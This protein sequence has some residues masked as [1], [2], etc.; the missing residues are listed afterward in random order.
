[1]KLFHM[2]IHVSTNFFVSAHNS[3]CCYYRDTYLDQTKST[4][5]CVHQLFHLR[6]LPIVHMY[7]LSVSLACWR[8]TCLS[9]AIFSPPTSLTHIG[10]MSHACPT[11]ITRVYHVCCTCTYCNTCTICTLLHTCARGM[12]CA[13]AVVHSI[14]TTQ[15]SPCLLG[16]AL[17]GTLP[18]ERIDNTSRSMMCV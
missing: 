8:W 2:H 17:S 5:T 4:F 12:L 14:T 6:H 18:E 3:L 11:H 9:A 16:S 13:M 7:L 10:H 1:M 15:C